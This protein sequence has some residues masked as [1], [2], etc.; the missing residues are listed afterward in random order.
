MLS[1]PT[2]AE[3]GGLALPVGLPSRRERVAALR[4]LVGRPDPAVRHLALGI[5][6]AARRHFEL[7]VTPL[8]TRHWPALIGEPFH[9]KLRIGACDLYASAPYTALFCAPRRPLVIR[10]VT[11]VAD[12]LPLPPPAMALLGRAAMEIIGRLALPDEHR[13]IALIA[14]FIVVVD[15]VFDHVLTEPAEE[16]GRRLAAVIDGREAP[17]TPELAL[18]RALAAAMGEG[19]RG[20]ERADFEHAMAQLKGWIRAEVAALRGDPDPRGLGHRMAGVE[21]TIDGLLFPVARYAG[22]SARAWMI[23]VSFFVQVADDWLDAEDDARAGRPTPV[24]DGAWTMADVASTWGRTLTGVEELVRDAGLRSPRYA[25][26]VRDA[27]AL[28]MAE[29]LEAMASRPGQ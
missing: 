2:A 4:A 22:S 18:T 17:T 13:R 9:A 29:V 5:R 15:H 6:A 8:V 16:R 10:A 1:A 14:A 21:G 23:D 12:R 11:D 26:F 25:R 3:P 28:M 20:R 24:L 27:Y 7:H 19:L